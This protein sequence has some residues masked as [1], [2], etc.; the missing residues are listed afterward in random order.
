MDELERQ[1][2][3]QEALAPLIHTYRM[4]IETLIFAWLAETGHG[5]K[6]FEIKTKTELGV[7]GKVIHTWIEPKVRI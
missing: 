7:N 5:L 3:E 2:A 6:D 1:Q 4:G